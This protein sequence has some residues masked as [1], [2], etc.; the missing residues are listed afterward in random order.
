MSRSLVGWPAA[1][2]VSVAASGGQS[3]RRH[4]ELLLPGRLRIVPRGRA[5]A[6]VLVN[7]RT[8]GATRW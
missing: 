7:G 5:V 1:L 2:A 8:P 4:G 6:A 3:E